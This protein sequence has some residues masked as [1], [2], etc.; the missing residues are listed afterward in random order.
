M[1][2]A[3]ASPRD[4][5]PWTGR[6]TA[7]PRTPVAAGAPWPLP[8]GLHPL[9]QGGGRDGTLRVPPEDPALSGAPL[10]LIVML[11]GAGSGAE[12]ALRRLAPIA[13]AALL[14]LPE[15]LGATWDI[16]ED[17]AYGPDIVRLDAALERIFAAWPVDPARL[18][19][20][21]FS[22]GASYAFS[23]G[24]MNGD[25][26]SHAPAFSPGFAAPTRIVEGARFYVSHGTADEILPIEQ[27]SRRLVPKL[28]Q[29]GFAVRYVEFDG[30]HV[31][32]PVVLR[33]ALDFL[34][35]P[36]G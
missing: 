14:A 6:L 24:L 33:D 11:H 2:A 1:A 31:L 21:G 5:G 34:N 17:R 26:F 8:P 36:D 18:A 12:R 7:R 20:A 4:E 35:A 23:L 30:G 25:L 32:P 27:C 10:P 28:R 19:I 9:G 16:I 22:D 15:S 3:E 29:R 13:D